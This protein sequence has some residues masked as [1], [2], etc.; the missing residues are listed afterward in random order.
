MSDHVPSTASPS[1][2]KGGT[3]PGAASRLL[4]GSRIAVSRIA[5]A[6][7]AALVL[8]AR[9]SWAGNHEVL[10]HLLLTFGLLLTGVA[11]AGRLWCSL[12]IAGNKNRV[13]V[14]QGPYSLCR[15]PL[16]LFSGIGAFGAAC[17]TGTISIPLLMLVIYTLAYQP[18][19]AGEEAFLT[20]KFGDAYRDFV[21]RV[22]RILP[23]FANYTPG[24]TVQANVAIFTS[25]AKSVIW[26]PAA[27][28]LIH[29][30]SSQ[31][32][33]PVWLRLP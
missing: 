21:A 33:L 26:F 32:L 23:S 20:K 15:H 12:Y 22:P 5:F 24:D 8:F 27:A 11:A 10:A 29:L 7:L 25:H 17:A 30:L 4:T 9:S 13:V 16:Y 14:C 3:Q 28:G 18:V 6:G 2:K 19:M 31:T 1:G